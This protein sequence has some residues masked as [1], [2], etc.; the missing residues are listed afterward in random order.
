MNCLKLAILKRKKRQKNMFRIV[1]KDDVALFKEMEAERIQRVLAQYIKNGLHMRKLM[2][3][4]QV[5]EELMSQSE[6]KTTLKSIIRLL[7]I[8]SE[9]RVGRTMFGEMWNSPMD[10]SNAMMHW[11]M[12]EVVGRIADHNRKA[13]FTELAKY[14]NCFQCL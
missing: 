2:P 14:I 13:A 10:S 12:F 11:K 6:V 7:K 4:G 5:S 9:D 1:G 8:S 3:D